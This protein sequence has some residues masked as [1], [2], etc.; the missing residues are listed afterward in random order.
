[1]MSKEPE[2]KTNRHAHITR[3]Q[4][5]QGIRACFQKEAKRVRFSNQPQT[6][7]FW[8]HL[9]KRKIKEVL[10]TDHVQAGLA[11]HDNHRN[12]SAC[13]QFCSVLAQILTVFLSAPYA[14][15]CL[16]ILAEIYFKNG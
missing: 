9:S 7:A 14:H 5:K 3:D 16:R 15:I 12:F 13:A 8:A 2:P 11:I 1:M 6:G 10:T 4:T